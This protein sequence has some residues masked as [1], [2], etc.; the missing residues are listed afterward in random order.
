MERARDSG[1][2]GELATPYFYY[3]AR[4]TAFPRSG[5]SRALAETSR[6]TLARWQLTQAALE[7]ID[8]RFGSDGA[9]L[10][11]H[12]RSLPCSALVQL[13]AQARELGSVEVDAGSMRCRLCP[14]HLDLCEMARVL[15]WRTTGGGRLALAGAPSAK[16]V[17]IWKEEGATCVVSLL[18]EAE[19]QFSRAREECIRNGLRWEHAPLSG[20]S[21]VTRPDELDM[22]SWKEMRDLLPRLLETE[23][24]VLHC[25]AGMH[26]TGTAAL[27]ALRRCG[28]QAP[29]ALGMIATMRTVTHAELLK[30]QRHFGEQ[31][32]WELADM[33]FEG[34]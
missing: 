8:K 13:S 14:A 33:L 2:A 28:V 12:L 22:H 26:R 23:S 16:T 21:A 15:Q 29:E 6:P 10:K 11:A 32:L 1:V 17:K 30:G 31:P 7:A 4:A 19:P 5:G 3:R 34:L 20:K 9:A 24:L 25:A 27:L 18:R